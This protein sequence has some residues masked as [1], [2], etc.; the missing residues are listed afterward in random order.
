MPPSVCLQSTK[1]FCST[2]DV[3]ILLAISMK[4]IA[5]WVQTAQEVTSL[6]LVTSHAVLLLWGFP[7][8]R[9]EQMSADHG[10]Y[11]CLQ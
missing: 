7:T 11:H 10:E 4:V 9:L 1:T 2:E 8:G 3:Y 5:S 6:L